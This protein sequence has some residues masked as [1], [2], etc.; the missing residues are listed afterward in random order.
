MLDLLQCAWTLDAIPH[1][2]QSPSTA[3]LFIVFSNINPPLPS[4]IAS[5]GAII[6]TGGGDSKVKLWSPTSGFCFVTFNEHTAAITDIAF[7]PHGAVLI[8]YELV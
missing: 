8:L 5:G 6:A 4:C 7:V 2:Y 1:P 3:L